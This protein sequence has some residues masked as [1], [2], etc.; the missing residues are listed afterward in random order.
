MFDNP[1]IGLLSFRK[2]K[3]APPK[4]G[5]T[6]YFTEKLKAVIAPETGIQ[7]PTLEMRSII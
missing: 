3:N 5:A 2:L 6:P 7:F 4:V 1:V